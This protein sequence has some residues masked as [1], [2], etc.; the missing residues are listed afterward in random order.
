MM[1]TG[2][3][4]GGGGEGRGGSAGSEIGH[5]HQGVVQGPCVCCLSSFCDEG[6]MDE[7]A[8]Q[9][10]SGQHGVGQSYAGTAVPHW[11]VSSEPPRGLGTGQGVWRSPDPRQATWDPRLQPRAKHRLFLHHAM[12]CPSCF[13]ILHSNAPSAVIGIAIPDPAAAPPVP[14]PV[15]SSSTLGCVDGTQE[16][17]RIEPKT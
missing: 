13:A 2:K 8:A 11:S 5:D 6:R 14:R 12:A 17:P 15:V 1:F 3:A 7:T 16:T 4:R 10:G 9:G